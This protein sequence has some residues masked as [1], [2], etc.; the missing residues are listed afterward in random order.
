MEPELV[1]ELIGYTASL[2]VAISLMMS[3]IGFC[4]RLSG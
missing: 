1:Y 3:S 4:L 2:L